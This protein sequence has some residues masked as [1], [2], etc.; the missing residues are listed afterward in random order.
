MNTEKQ[1]GLSWVNIILVSLTRIFRN[2]VDQISN[3]GQFESL[4]P[5]VRQARNRSWFHV[6][7]RIVSCW[8]L[9]KWNRVNSIRLYPDSEESEFWRRLWQAFPVK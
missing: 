6:S 9:F 5:H 7:L 4:L 3:M 8:N 2:W 1:S